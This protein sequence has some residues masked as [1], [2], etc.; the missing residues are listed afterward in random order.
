MNA[1]EFHNLL[2]RTLLQHGFPL[3]D[4]QIDQF[5]AYWAEL[6]RWNSRINLTSIRD[7]REIIVKHFLDSL[8]VLHHFSIKPGD[9]VIDIGTGAGFPG[10]PI[11]IYI[12]DIQ[13]VLVESSFKKVSFLRFLV[14]QL[15]PRVVKSNSDP[16]A[17]S[18]Q[19][20]SLSLVRPW[21]EVCVI[22]QRAE[23]Y[24]RQVQHTYAYDWVLTRYIASLEDSVAYCIPLLK[25]N[26]TWIAYK[27]CRV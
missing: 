22:A 24:A 25:S 13:L 1:N 20:L 12:P 11:K 27:S 14:S 2:E 21:T 18:G 7:D 23:E 3:T 8:G 6:K 9:S 15:N 4:L 10:I 19:V 17:G 16:S 26:G 5:V